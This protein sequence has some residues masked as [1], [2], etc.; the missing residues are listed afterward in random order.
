[1]T[2]NIPDVIWAFT[3]VIAAASEKCVEMEARPKYAG[4]S[5]IDGDVSV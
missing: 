5:T 4:E 3:D 1:M 2:D